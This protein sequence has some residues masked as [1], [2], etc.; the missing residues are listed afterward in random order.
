MGIT[1]Q[2]TQINYWLLQRWTMEWQE[3]AKPRLPNFI[4]LLQKARASAAATDSWS[5]GQSFLTGSPSAN[6]LNNQ[7]YF[8]C[9]YNCISLSS[10]T[11]FL[12]LC[13]NCTL[14]T[15]S[16][17]YCISPSLCLDRVAD[18]WRSLIGRWIML[19]RAQTD[20]SRSTDHL[21]GHGGGTKLF[22]QVP[23]TLCCTKY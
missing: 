5:R 13:Q 6:F 23:S 2:E 16:T 20:S 22:Y 9:G 7:Q 1:Y 8:S 18:S 21:V 12:P 17:T 11:V 14:F 3:G 19:E 10:R 15:F 4:W